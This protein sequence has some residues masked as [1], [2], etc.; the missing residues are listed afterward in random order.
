MA[1]VWIFFFQNETGQK[2]RAHKATSGTQHWVKHAAIFFLPKRLSFLQR[3]FCFW[4][5]LTCLFFTSGV[6]CSNSKQKHSTFT[7]LCFQPLFSYFTRGKIA[8]IIDHFRC[9][10]VSSGIKVQSRHLYSQQDKCQH[11]HFHGLG[12]SETSFLIHMHSTLSSSLWGWRRGNNS[13]I[14]ISQKISFQGK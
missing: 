7:Q 13:H 10:P 3:N 1:W 12:A 11:L 5:H 6:G 8:K 4:F 14:L 2:W 9:T